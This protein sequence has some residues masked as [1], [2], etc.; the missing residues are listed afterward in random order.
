MS[1]VA[2][3]YALTPTGVTTVVENV[4]VE[5]EMA[6]IDVDLAKE[7]TIELVDPNV[8]VTLDEEIDVEVPC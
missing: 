5:L 2:Y 4:E 1:I 7:I 6:E 3:G 8:D